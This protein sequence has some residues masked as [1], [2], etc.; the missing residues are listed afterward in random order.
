[1]HT[2]FVAALLT[3]TMAVSCLPAAQAQQ[4]PPLITVPIG[5]VV[6]LTLVN[7]IKKKSSKPG[8]TVRAMVA[9]PITVGEQV[10][11][12]AG[13][14][15]E[16]VLGQSLPKSKRQPVAPIQVH[17]TRIVFANGYSAPLDAM[18][19]SM[20]PALPLSPSSQSPTQPPTMALMAGVNSFSP[21]GLLDSVRDLLLSSPWSGWRTW[22]MSPQVVPPSALPPPAPLPHVGPGTGV[23]VGI[24]LASVTPIIITLLFFHR[25]AGNSDYIVHNAGWQFQM[26][27]TAPLSLNTALTAPAQSGAVN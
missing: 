16:G 2:R 14:Y 12:P 8:D 13:A 1:M 19:A 6:P 3:A 18:Q 9:F 22:L 25:K 20:P 10:A 5:T 27:L 17:F 23:I 21:F 15:V 7:P 26:K 4:P 24:A 11:I